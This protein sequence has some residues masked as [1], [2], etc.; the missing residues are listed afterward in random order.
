M[1]RNVEISPLSAFIAFMIGATLLGIVGAL[2]A[3]PMA[4]IARVT[5]EEMFVS[6]RERRLDI[7]R[8]GTLRR[9]V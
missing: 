3:I 2:M 7:E 9:K 8:A 1:A 6:R 4:A 5:F